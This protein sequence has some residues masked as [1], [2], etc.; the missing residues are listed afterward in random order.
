MRYCISDKAKDYPVY[1]A[2]RE[3]SYGRIRKD[4]FGTGSYYAIFAKDGWLY[5]LDGCMM[6]GHRAKVMKDGR[7]KFVPC[8]HGAIIEES[9]L[10]VVPKIEVIT[11]AEYEKLELS[12]KTFTSSEVIAAATKKTDENIWFDCRYGSLIEKIK[13]DSAGTRKI[14]LHETVKMSNDYT[15]VYLVSCWRY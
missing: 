13:F 4:N 2:M 7:Y 5:A 12:T 10:G 9:E 8:K 3:L 1:R 6:I 15:H 14:D 11:M